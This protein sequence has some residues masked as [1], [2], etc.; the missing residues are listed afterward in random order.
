MRLLQNI[1]ATVCMA[2]AL[3]LLGAFVSYHADDPVAL[4]A[5]LD[6]AALAN[7][8]GKYGAHISAWML[9]LWGTAALLFIPALLLLGIDLLRG[10]EN[11]GLFGRTG[12]LFLFIPV[13]AVMLYTMQLEWYGAIRPGGICGQLLA[14]GL[15]S[16][17]DA[18]LLPMVIFFTTWSM[19]LL[20]VGFAWVAPCVVM[21]KKCAAYLRIDVTAYTI[22]LHAETFYK[23]VQH[24]FVTFGKKIKSRFWHEPEAPVQDELETIV[25][26]TAFWE[27]HVPSSAEATAEFTVNPAVEQQKQD[28]LQDLHVV[29]L[30]PSKSPEQ[31][32][33]EI[34]QRVYLKP[35]VS[36][37]VQKRN[38]ITKS[39]RNEQQ[40]QAQVLEEKLKR[41][42][43]K[44][45]VLNITAGPVVTLFEYQPHIDVPISKIIAR[46]DDLALA[47]QAMSLRIIAPIPGKSVIGFEVAN[48]KRK[49]VFFSDSVNSE[50]FMKSDAQLPLIIGQNTIGEQA[51]IDL[52]KMPHLLVA[53]STGSGKS[54][55][56]NTMLLSLLCRATP[57]EVRLI[58]I[59]PKRLEFTAYADIPHLL[60][61]IV[62]D[63]KAALTVLQWAITTMESRYEQMAAAAV[64]NIY[65]YRT[66]KPGSMPY[67]VIV[68]DELADLMMVV[69]KDI[70]G[71]IA[72]LAQMA[73]AAGIHLVLATQRPSVDVITGVVKVN[74]PARLAC[75]VTSKVDSRTILDT[76]GAEKLLGKGDMLFLDTQGKLS[77]LHGAY[78]TDQEIAHIVSHVKSQRTVVYEQLPV[79][80]KDCAV[81]GEDAVL[82]KELIDFVKTVDEVS[83]SLLQRKFRIGYNR[84]ARLIDILEAQGVIMPSSGSKTRKVLH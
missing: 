44:G 10:E 24:A 68:I 8:C 36:S 53:G 55:A 28:I 30:E 20:L 73:R 59:D 64:R 21:L 57:D 48:V 32:V 83:I 19:L 39:D 23:T 14:Q 33:Q 75:K 27:Q 60:F 22:F 58:L 67:I 71:S 81:Q 63:P 3:F 56:L 26:D 2:A 29:P 69:G 4:Y 82:Y 17:I 61:P 12:I 40:S 72:R 77:R 47:L 51:I 25:Y 15:G 84:S 34:K 79:T 62:V 11:R 16:V 52:T 49:T 42:G 37:F 45:S 78:V 18:R 35:D 50:A 70:E 66:L 5:T 13:V 41:F 43:I 38:E 31:P 9:Y 65:D 74:F 1:G 54:V 6:T 46:E 76:G 7:W 80:D